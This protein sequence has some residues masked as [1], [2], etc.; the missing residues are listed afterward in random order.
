MYSHRQLN[1]CHLTVVT[2]YCM[3]NNYTALHTISIDV[4]SSNLFD[5]RYTYVSETHFPVLY[6][7]IQGI[8]PV[9]RNAG[10][11]VLQ[12][13][14]TPCNTPAT[15]PNFPDA[16][17][18]FQRLSTGGTP[19]N[20]G[21]A[22]NGAPPPVSPLATHPP[23]PQHNPFNGSPNSQSNYMPLSRSATVSICILICTTI[24]L[25]LKLPTS[26]VPNLGSLK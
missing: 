14:M 15:P 22:T 17:A 1:V 26:C 5:A 9:N 24:L 21:P 23:A 8:R 2:S 13:L 10:L 6:R 12:Q 4:L 25:V 16:L 19:S 11:T 18:A 7:T 3:Y 20:M